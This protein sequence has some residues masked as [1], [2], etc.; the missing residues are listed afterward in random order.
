MTNVVN[1]R[2]RFGA[3]GTLSRLLTGFLL[4]GVAAATAQSQPAG[5]S[6][7]PRFSVEEATIADLHRAIQHGQT[8]C[9]AI[10]ESYIERARAYN[11]V[12]TQLVTRDGKPVSV[13]T[14]PVRGGSRVA[15]P[16]A[17]MA[18]ASTLPKVEEY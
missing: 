2:R 13:A 7:T 17:T 14:G 11:G 4:A 10:V 16:T 5:P 1:V 6:R 15:F 3:N 8:T 18:I 9:R 12:C